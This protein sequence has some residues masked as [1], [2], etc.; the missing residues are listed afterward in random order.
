MR[1]IE[2]S[3]PPLNKFT[4]SQL[5]GCVDGAHHP[6]THPATQPPSQGGRGGAGRGAARRGGAGRGVPH[7]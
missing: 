4:G 1:K 5:C 3:A 6:A 2:V 7:P